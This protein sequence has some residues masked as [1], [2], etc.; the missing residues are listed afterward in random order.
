MNYL[1]HFRAAL[2]ASS[3]L[4]LALISRTHAQDVWFGTATSPHGDSKGIY[5]ATFDADKGKL[6]EP[7]LAAEV[8]NPGFLA[9]HP[10]L[11]VLYACAATADGPG[12]A[13]FAIGEGG[14]LEPLG[15]Q[16]IGDG[17]AAHLSVHPSGKILITAQYGGGSTAVFP[18]GADGKIGPRSQLL[19]HE[20]GTGVVKGRQDAPHAH[21]TGFDKAGNFAFVPDLGMDGVVIYKVAADG[22]SLEKHGFGES[23]A[24]GGARHMAFSPD[25]KIAYVLNELSLTVTSFNYDA[26]AG[27]LKAIATVPALSEEQK[28]GE[29]FN[30]ASEIRVHPSGKWV[31]SANRGHDSVTAFRADGSGGLELLEVEP[32]RG[33]FPRNFNL[34]PSGRWLL[35]AG[36]QSATVS[37]FAIDQRS[38]MLTFVQGSIVRVPGAICVLFGR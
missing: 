7:K 9:L 37:V 35:A 33:A 13:A 1:Q 19:K 26:E 30:S 22:T 5:H 28:A 25:E 4:T 3:F 23:E 20:G 15:S 21:W 32:I 27:T 29:T 12:V 24:G 8:G 36:A 38:G 16:V 14:K 2:V 10:G 34:D 18:L 11:D 31:Y 17:G 6:T